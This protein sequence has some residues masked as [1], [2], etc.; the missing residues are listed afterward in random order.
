MLFA[1]S[2]FAVPEKILNRSSC[3]LP[4]P[5]R[6]F[7]ARSQAHGRE[8]SVKKA[9]RAD[10]TGLSFPLFNCRL[11]DFLR[12]DAAKVQR[13]RERLNAPWTRRAYLS[14]EMVSQTKVWS[15]GN[16]TAARRAFAG[17]GKKPITAEPL[18]ASKASVAPL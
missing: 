13:R 3:T 17:L 8:Y 1:K 11:F 6:S 4:L 18:P 10:T 12:R 15:C 14:R 16:P 2:G 7:A 9:K 5:S